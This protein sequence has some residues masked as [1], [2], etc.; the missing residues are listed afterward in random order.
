M[1]TPFIHQLLLLLNN[2]TSYGSATYEFTL[3]LCHSALLSQSNRLGY[4]WREIDDLR[5]FQVPRSVHGRK[6]RRQVSNKVNLTM[7]NA[8]KQEGTSTNKN[9]LLTSTES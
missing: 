4:F 1:T 5:V 9:I 7:S 8:E 3:L 6:V 2:T